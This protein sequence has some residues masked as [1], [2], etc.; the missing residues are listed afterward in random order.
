MY[1]TSYRILNNAADA[2]DIM[3]DSFMDAF[4]KIGDYSGEGSFAGWLRRIVVNN[5]ID[6]LKKKKELVP[7]EEKDLGIEPDELTKMNERENTAEYRVDEIKKAISKLPDD[8][9][10][11]ISLYLLEGYDHEE[12]SQILDISYNAA[13]TRYSRAKNKLINMLNEQRKM[14]MFNPN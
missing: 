13:R 12:S 14:K 11:I 6:A 10:V 2:E 4:R 8:A 7:L 3:Q 1:N 9:R 5:S